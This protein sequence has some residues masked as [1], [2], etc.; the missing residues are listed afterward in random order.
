MINDAEDFFDLTDFAE[1]VT[2]NGKRLKAIFD[3]PRV[4]YQEGFAVL[5][6]N[7]PQLTCQTV[8]IEKANAVQG[9]PVIVRRQ[10][11]TVS[12]ISDDGTGI[13]IINLHQAT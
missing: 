8:D 13:S 4:Q 2:V 6:A 1:P 9:S 11:Y 10:N 12:E 5:V 3:K 7:Q